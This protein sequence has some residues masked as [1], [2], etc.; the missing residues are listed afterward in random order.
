MRRVQL[1]ASRMFTKSKEAVL[2]PE[3]SAAIVQLLKIAS[4]I[5]VPFC[6]TACNAII[7]FIEMGEAAGTND[8]QWQMLL[9]AIKIYACR[10]SEFME[11]ISEGRPSDYLAISDDLRARIARGAVKDFETTIACTKS[12]VESRL[13]NGNVKKRVAATVIR[14][15]IVECRQMI[16][17]AH[18]QFNDRLLNI[19]T[20]S[21]SG[22]AITSGLLTPEEPK[23]DIPGARILG[24]HDL[25]ILEDVEIATLVQDSFWTNLVRVEVHNKVRIAKIYSPSNG[26]KEKFKKDLKFLANHWVPRMVRIFGYNPHSQTPFVVFTFCDESGLS[27]SNLQAA[28][29][30]LVTEYLFGFVDRRSVE[31][32]TSIR[33]ALRDATVDL[34]GKLIVAPLTH[35]SPADQ[36]IRT[37][38]NTNRKG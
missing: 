28:Q 27:E 17:T 31:E 25:E 4:T 29:T 35:D 34:N 2:S 15:E 3:A 36:S 7:A 33:M 14:E 12:K 5:N 1:A 37:P 13:R 26:G 23:Y 6:Q 19:L 16:A 22:A 8:R 24:G 18:E 20:I 38:N 30:E 11:A 21:H 9:D 10:I 32:L